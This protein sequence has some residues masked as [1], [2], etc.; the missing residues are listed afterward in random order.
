MGAQEFVFWLKGYIAA[1]GDANSD[2]VKAELKK[3]VIPFAY[4][5]SQWP[6]PAI[7]TTPAIAP[8]PTIYPTITWTSQD[9]T[10]K[11]P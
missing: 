11:N 4:I 6:L 9:Y 1:G 8:T 5:G 10:N 3:V 7:T 2:I